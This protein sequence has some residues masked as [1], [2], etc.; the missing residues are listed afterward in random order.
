M[1]RA[2][3]RRPSRLLLSTPRR[4][5]GPLR[6]HPE[7]GR[8]RDPERE[9]HTAEPDTPAERPRARRRADRRPATP[10]PRA[11]RSTG[12]PRRTA[13]ARPDP[14]IRSERGPARQRPPDTS[15]DSTGSTPHTANTAT[16]APSS[17]RQLPALDR[18]RDDLHQEPEQPNRDRRARRTLRRHAQQPTRCARTRRVTQATTTAVQEREK[19]QLP[20]SEGRGK[21]AGREGAGGGWKVGRSGPLARP[22]IPEGVPDAGRQVKTEER[23]LTRR[24]TPGSASTCLGRRGNRTSARRASAAQG[25]ARR[26]RRSIRWRHE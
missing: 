10:S 15:T 20:G 14:R 5:L 9:V 12:R 3:R 18:H 19:Q 25:D 2:A 23:V 8:A 21:T 4:R 1:R 11:R 13:S 6:A 24:P 26:R 22:V 7:A 17:S 16:H